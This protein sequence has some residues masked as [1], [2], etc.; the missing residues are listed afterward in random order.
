M[1]AN[2]YAVQPEFIAPTNRRAFCRGD[3]LARLRAYMARLAF[4]APAV[5][6]H[7]SLYADKGLAVKS[8]PYETVQLVPRVCGA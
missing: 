6:I 5:L 4:L 1:I 3:W 2:H 7:I 8:R